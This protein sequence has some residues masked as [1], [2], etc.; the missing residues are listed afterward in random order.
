MMASGVFNSC[1][2]DAKARKRRCNSSC[3]ASAV[4][5]TP[6]LN[7]WSVVDAKHFSCWGK[8]L[9][10]AHFRGQRHFWGRELTA[11]ESE[12]FVQRYVSVRLYK[13]TTSQVSQRKRYFLFTCEKKIGTLVTSSRND[14]GKNF[15]LDKMRL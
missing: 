4:L 2:T 9:S 10:W 8:D 12:C 6:E 11:W 7:V 13:T 14:C 5:T 15:T 1:A 3:N